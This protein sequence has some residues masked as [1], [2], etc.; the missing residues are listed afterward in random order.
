MCFACCNLPITCFV[1]LIRFDVSPSTEAYGHHLG[2]AGAVRSK[3]TKPERLPTLA[4]KENNVRSL[5]L[6]E[7]DLNPGGGEEGN[8]GRSRE[9]SLLLT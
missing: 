7:E 4:E 5:R 9:Q 1:F 6:E 8:G 2:V 3:E